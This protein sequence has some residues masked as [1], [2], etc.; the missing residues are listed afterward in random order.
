MKTVIQILILSIIIFV[1][2]TLVTM[3]IETPFDGNDTY[4]FPF[5]FHIKWSEMCFECPE[6]P[7][8]TYYG[9]LFIDFLISGI[10]GF[11]LLKLFKQLKK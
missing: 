3:K 9:Y 6:N 11:G 4:G 10:I 2:I 5:T 1:V 8:E 7:T